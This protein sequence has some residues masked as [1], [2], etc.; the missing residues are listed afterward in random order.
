LIADAAGNLFG[1]TSTGGANG[2]GTVFEMV[3]NGGGNYM[4]T[5]LAS[6]DLS[7]N[8]ANPYAGLIADASGDLFGTTQSGGANGWGTVF[9]FPK[10]AA[11]TPARR[12][13]WSASTSPMG[14]THMPV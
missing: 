10:P 14:H 13:H 9:G 3:N 4:Q 1:T 2:W 12:P 5:T 11:A 8:G 7:S 6:F